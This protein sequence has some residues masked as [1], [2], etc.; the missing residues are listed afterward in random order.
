[1]S[2][3]RKRGHFD[4]EG[5]KIPSANSPIRVGSRQAGPPGKAPRWADSVHAAWIRVELRDARKRAAAQ[6][7]GTAHDEDED[8]AD[9]EPQAVA[10]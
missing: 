1:M 3:R 2:G 9:E 5:R 7:M 8:E 4:P 10:A 6:G